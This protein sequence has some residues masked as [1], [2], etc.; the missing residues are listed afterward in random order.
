MNEK[1][2]VILTALIDIFKFQGIT[3]LTINSSFSGV[4]SY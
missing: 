4:T 3:P 1:E 2:Y